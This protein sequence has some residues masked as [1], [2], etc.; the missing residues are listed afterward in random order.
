MSREL[1]FSDKRII[2]TLKSFVP[3]ALNTF[4]SQHATKKDAAR[5]FFFEIVDQADLYEDVPEHALPKGENPP[6][7]PP[8][9]VKKSPTGTTQGFYACAADKKLL[10]ARWGLFAIYG[11]DYLLKLL[12]GA[13]VR[14][15]PAPIDEVEAPRETPI[16]PKDAVVLN[17]Y[18]RAKPRP[19]DSFVLPETLDRAGRDVLW[20]TGKEVEQ[21][22][23]GRVAE[24]LA[25]RITTFHLVDTTRSLPDVFWSRVKEAAYEAKPEKTPEGVRVRISG[26]FSLSDKDSTHRYEGTL[27]GEL[28]YDARSKTVTS[29]RMIADG[30]VRGPALDDYPKWRRQEGYSLKIG[31]AL[32]T[33]EEDLKV[34]PVFMTMPDTREAYL[35]YRLN[36]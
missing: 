27:R 9:H 14:H 6:Y 3:V 16:V 20:V 30:V 26:K 4:E 12:R 18:A 2:E 10:F 29:F 7:P 23:G 11:P 21:L 15:A 5:E 24:E 17:V 8:Y 13:L 32:T 28:A 33:A 36:R 22:L 19:G 35:T 31:F 25:A 1:I 34:V